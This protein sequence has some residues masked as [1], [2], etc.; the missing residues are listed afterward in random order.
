MYADDLASQNLG[1]EITGVAPGRVTAVMA[2]G[3]G[4]VNGLGVCHGG[5]VFAL[6]DTALAFASN[7]YGERS[8]AA[9]ADI[10]FLEPVRAGARLTATADERARRGRSGV[11]D[12]TVRD[13]AGTVVA[14]LRGRTRS[15]G[16]PLL[17]PSPKE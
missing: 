6:A 10:N 11:Y 17:T 8:L 4:M 15:I 2:V 14:E 1:I 7:S 5:Y 3:P 13:E 9:G 12:V 16:Q